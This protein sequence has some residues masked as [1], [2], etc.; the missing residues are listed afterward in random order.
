MTAVSDAVVIGVV[1]GLV[2]A[3][4]S[5]YLFTRVSQLERKVGLM[6][7]ILL[8]LKV[9][10]EQTLLSAT[11]PHEHV[12]SSTSDLNTYREVVEQT[13]QG[14]NEIAGSSSK[15]AQ[16]RPFED[17]EESSGQEQGQ[18]TQ[19]GESREL[20]IE[21][22]P[23]AR[24]PQQSVQV[25]R[26]APAVSVN[27]EAMTYKELV[28]FAKQKGL[29]GLRNLSKKEVIDVLRRRDAGGPTSADVSDLSTWKNTTV[30]FGEGELQPLNDGTIEVDGVGSFG[31]TM[32]G[33]TPLEETTEVENSLV[34]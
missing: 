1:L 13:V 24:T 30:S 10:T 23:R 4:V 31:G 19:G 28:Q 17:A 15:A 29:T 26:D 25:E 14:G 8:D 6:E 9:T 11:E 3:A 2:F 33:A 7:N 5:Y 34:E 27:Y 32:L 22:V 12:N 21:S 16:I 18:E 20:F